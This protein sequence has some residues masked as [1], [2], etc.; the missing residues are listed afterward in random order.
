MSPV[1]ACLA[2]LFVLAYG[3]VAVFA[4]RRRELGRLA[5]RQAVRRKGQ[6]LLVVAGLMVGTAMITAALVAGD[7]AADTSLD[8]AVRS[9]GLVDLTVTVGDRFFPKDVA[10]RLAAAPVLP[11]WPM[12]W[13]PGS[14]WPGRWRTSTAGRGPRRSLWWGS[15]RAPSSS[16][17]PTS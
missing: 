4:L 3:G 12:A 14:S 11:A 2:G 16:S 13:R 1:V 6:T 15:T 8:I 10:D 17:A 5:V 7:S 9:W